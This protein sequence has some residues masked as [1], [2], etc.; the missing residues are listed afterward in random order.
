MAEGNGVAQVRILGMDAGGTMTDTIAVD[1]RGGF[2]IGKA[3]TTPHDEAEG[4]FSS[5]NDA[6]SYWDT[7]SRAVFPQL[8]RRS[9]RG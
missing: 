2:T 6:L 1:E 7:D 4:F 5:V 8:P 9:G 3:L